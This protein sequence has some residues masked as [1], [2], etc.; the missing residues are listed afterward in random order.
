V[1]VSAIGGVAAW[2]AAAAR[3]PIVAGVDRFLPPAFGRVHPRWG[4]PAVALVVQAVIAFVFVLLGQAGT[5]VKGAYDV[6]VS[7]SVITYFIPY[8]LMFA[9]LVR[10]DSRP[11]GTFLGTLG[12]VTTAISIALAVVPAQDDPNKVLAVTKTIGLTFVTIGVGALL[13]LSSRLRKQ[14]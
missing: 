8:L 12:F 5:S 7:M 11:A 3:L 14:S 13:Y 9:A 10:L 2:F 4:T 1:T 6:L